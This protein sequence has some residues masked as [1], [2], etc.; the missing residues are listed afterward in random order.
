M[1]IESE[2]HRLDI[3]E[4]SRALLEKAFQMLLNI[5]QRLERLE[6]GLLH[7][8][9]EENLSHEKHEWVRA[10]LSAGGLAFLCPEGKNH[11]VGDFVL[12]D[13][14]FPSLPEQRVVCS[15]KV[16]HFNKDQ[17]MAIDFLDIHKDD[18]EFIHRFVLEKEREILRARADDRKS[19]QD[20]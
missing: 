1:G 4:S 13:I 12:L 11:Q 7:P 3:H 10:D 5:D 18:K 8:Q 2:L 9:P 17:M 20:V 15:G 19:E 6:E 14:V 16:V